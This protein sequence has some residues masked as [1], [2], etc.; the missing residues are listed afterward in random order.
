ME[1]T[2]GISL[3]QWWRENA[4]VT[5]RENEVKLFYWEEEVV[6]D[7]GQGRGKAVFVSRQ[8]MSVGLAANGSWEGDILV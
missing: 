6:P 3:I 1:G 5:A 7:E 8:L 4:S 2:D